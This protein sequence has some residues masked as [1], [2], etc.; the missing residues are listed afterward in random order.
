MKWRKYLR[1]FHPHLVQTNIYCDETN[2][3]IIIIESA[4]KGDI[5]DPE[6]TFVIIPKSS[7]ILQPAMPSLSSWRDIFA[8]VPANYN[9]TSQPVLYSPE[10]CAKKETTRS[11]LKV[12][13]V[14]TGTM[15]IVGIASAK[16]VGLEMFGILQLAFF[17]LAN[18]DSLDL[19]L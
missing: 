13:F 6:N 3:Y 9:S 12:S 1:I 17:N 19:N 5:T 18:H 10:E 16:I 4:I 7:L 14:L 8:K 2:P 11:M 15:M